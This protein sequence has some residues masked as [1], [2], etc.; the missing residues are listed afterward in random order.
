MAKSKKSNEEI[1]EEAVNNDPVINTMK[2][3]CDGVRRGSLKENGN[4][5]VG[6]TANLLF[7]NNK[8]GV[9]S[10]VD[11]SE[12]Q[13]TVDVRFLFGSQKDKVKKLRCDPMQLF[14]VCDVESASIMALSLK[15]N[16]ME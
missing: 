12:A 11:F 10:V 8:I 6:K 7:L 5:I 15:D 16:I 1:V 14:D 4:L 13:K 9:V 3:I 2:E